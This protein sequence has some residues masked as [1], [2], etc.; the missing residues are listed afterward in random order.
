MGIPRHWSLDTGTGRNFITSKAAKI[1][2]LNV[3]KYE[4]FS[5]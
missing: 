3:T 5:P 1:S 4:R 2:K